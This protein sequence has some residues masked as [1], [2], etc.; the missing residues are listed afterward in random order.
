MDLSEKV[1][2]PFQMMGRNANPAKYFP[3][4]RCVELQQTDD[5]ISNQSIFPKI[6]FDKTFSPL[7]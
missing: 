3:E 6:R 4:K 5:R 7:R 2:T 1:E